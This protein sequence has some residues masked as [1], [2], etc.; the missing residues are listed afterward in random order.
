MKYIP[1]LL[2]ILFLTG[3][4]HNKSENCDLLLFHKQVANAEVI[5]YEHLQAIDN[6]FN[7]SF[8]FDTSIVRVFKFAQDSFSFHI[9]KQDSEWLYNNENLVYLNHLDSS[10][11]E[12]SISF[13]EMRHS[14]QY[15]IWQNN[16]LSAI[17][18]IE[19]H[20]CRLSNS[21]K[22]PVYSIDFENQSK[23]KSGDEEIVRWKYQYSIPEVYN[24]SFKHKAI[25]IKGMDTLQIQFH[26]YHRINNNP[27]SKLYQLSERFKNNNYPLE[28]GN[29]DL[30]FGSEPISTGARI[31]KDNYIDINGNQI[32]I[33]STEKEY[34]I[35][36]FSVIGCGFSESAL[37]DLKIDEYELKSHANLYYSSFQNNNVAIQNYIEDKPYFKNAFAMESNMIMDFRLPVSPTFVVINGHGV[38]T[39]IVEGYDETVLKELHDLITNQVK[40]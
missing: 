28:N 39:K 22:D 17:D 30:P 8:R 27:Q 2:S 19:S 34:S 32:S 3:C 26:T 10:K 12:E 18:S 38:I 5:E 13:D 37:Y 9:L 36:M 21:K 4:D 24:N 11:T 23:S 1:L 31:V 16:L 35:L 29:D 25:T 20:S 14:D 33:V 15:P 40:Q 7:S 6:R